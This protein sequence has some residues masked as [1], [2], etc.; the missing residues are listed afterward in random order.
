MIF[1]D[2]G[3]DN[4]LEAFKSSITAII[5]TYQKI[6]KKKLL[7]VKIMHAIKRIASFICL[8]LLLLKCVLIT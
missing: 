3:L 5:F 4:F 8:M 6:L 2:R 1:V 7:E